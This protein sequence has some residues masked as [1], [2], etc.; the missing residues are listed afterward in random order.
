MAYFSYQGRV[1]RAG[2]ILLKA[3]PPSSWGEVTDRMLHDWPTKPMLR[4]IAALSFAILTTK[5]VQLPKIALHIPWE[6]SLSNLI[7]RPE[8][9]LKNP[10]FEEHQLWTPFA[11][12]ILDQAKNTTLRLVMDRKIGRAHV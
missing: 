1:P 12:D 2:G 4:N 8:R 6:S 5:D 7:Q 9:L 11:K 3:L 10:R